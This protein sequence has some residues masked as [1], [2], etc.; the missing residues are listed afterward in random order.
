MLN[1]LVVFGFVTCERAKETCFR[2]LTKVNVELPVP[3]SK[4]SLP[5][6]RYCLLL[7][8]LL[9]NANKATEELVCRR[10]EIRP[11]RLLRP[12]YGRVGSLAPPYL[13]IFELLAPVIEITIFATVLRVALWHLASETI[14]LEVYD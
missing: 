12:R 2:L 5:F 3:L 1:V 14:L 8:I 11:L 4:F 7:S 13:W 10:K 6:W 9:R